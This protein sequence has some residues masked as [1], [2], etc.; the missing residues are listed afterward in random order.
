[1]EHHSNDL[2][3]RHRGEVL[4][5]GVHKDGTLDMNDLEHKLAKHKVKLVA[6][7]G[8]SNVTGSIN[9]IHRIAELAHKH[10]ARILV[11]AA[12]ILAHKQIDVKPNN[13]PAHIDF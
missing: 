11:D 10:G 4:H 3:H 9:D 5:F 6:V 8:A 2:P 7:T 1:M 13:D 12:Q